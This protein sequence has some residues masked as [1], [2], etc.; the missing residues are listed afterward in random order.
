[1]VYVCV[2]QEEFYSA[3]KLIWRAFAIV[4]FFTAQPWRLLSP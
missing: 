1:M 2:K 3:F 4:A